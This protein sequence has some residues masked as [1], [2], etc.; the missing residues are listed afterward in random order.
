MFFSFICISTERKNNTH[1]GG[2][3]DAFLMPRGYP[4]AWSCLLY[5]PCTDAHRIHYPADGS[6]IVL[7][8]TRV[9]P[10]MFAQH[11]IRWWVSDLMPGSYNR[12]LIAVLRHHRHAA[13]AAAAGVRSAAWRRFL[14]DPRTERDCFSCWL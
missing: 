3:V 14:F 2:I 12:C 13:T 11:I 7:T 6:K 10:L 5:S 8:L 9:L 1:V 4:G